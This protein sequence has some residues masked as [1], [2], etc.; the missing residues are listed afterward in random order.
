MSTRSETLLGDTSRFAVKIAFIDDSSEL[1]M[2]TD[3]TASWGSFEIWVNGANICAH[4]EEGEVV[5]GVHW[6]LLPLLEWFAANW[7]PMLHEERFPV[8][9]AGSDAVESLYRTRFAPPGLPEERAMQ[10]DEDW[11]EW[12]QRHGLHAARDGGLFPEIFFRRFE[13]EIEISWSNR[14]PLG[15]PD[16]FAFLVP[17]GRAML[18][19]A[20]V[21]QPLFGV[22]RSATEHLV[23]V[24]RSERLEALHLA[25]KD[26]NKQQKQRTS[27]LDWLFDLRVAETGTESWDAVKRLFAGTTARIR[28]AVVEPEGSGLV[29]RGSSHAVLL[30]GSVAPEIAEVDARQLAQQ[31]VD[32]FDD[33]G[34]S[35][36]LEELVEVATS[37][38]LEG[39]PWEQGYE[40]ADLVRQ[41]VLESLPPT[42]D[43]HDVFEA[44]GIGIDAIT[45]TDPRIRGI[46]IAGPQHRPAALVNQSH[47][48]NQ[49]DE[50][51]RF[52]LAHELCHLIL[53][54]RI[55]RKLAVASGP[56]APIEI[57]Q[58]A[59][60]FAAYFLMP[61]DEIQAVLAELDQELA[62]HEGIRAVAE[63]FGTSPRATLEHLHNLGW[64]DEFE[65][66]TLRGTGIDDESFSRPPAEIGG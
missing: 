5:D 17:H 32:R 56:W 44:V 55:G 38:N 12:R 59:N 51:R 48:R 11:F 24:A 7:N 65:R 64:L 29:L 10:H 37:A 45:L 22:L 54:R 47:P 50:G 27:R 30:F 9:N 2:D 33:A 36:V 8:R 3:M 14:A 42:T 43:I 20:A 16:G 46:A 4:V 34:D 26:L 63:R 52:T 58:R 23:N 40:L 21:A 13:D 15:S 62:T 25:V 57:E 28:R 31:L 35:P 1:P 53:D 49:S 61:P 66:D 39:L 41:V 6:Y 18:D 19:P 60:A